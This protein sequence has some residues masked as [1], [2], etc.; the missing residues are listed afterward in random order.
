MVNSLVG[1]GAE[2]IVTLLAE[3]LSQRSGMQLTLL[4]LE[5]GDFYSVPKSVNVHRLYRHNKIGVLYKLIA[6]FLLARELSKFVKKNNIQIVQSHLY[7]A[8]YVNVLSRLFGANHKVELVN[9][10][11][12]SR[13]SLVTIR[14]I[15]NRLLTKALYKKADVLVFLSRG[16]KRDFLTHGI[17]SSDMRVINN[18]YDLNSIREWSLK[19]LH[20]PVKNDGEFWLISVGRLI[21]L[22]RTLDI[23]RAFEK[24]SAKYSYAR[25][26]LVGDGVEKNKLQEY[27]ADSRHMANAVFFTGQVSNPYAYMRNSDVLIL[28]SETEGFPNVIVEALACDTP[29]IATD[30]VSGPR[31]IL[32]PDT[33]DRQLL[34]GEIEYAQYGMLIPVGDVDCLCAA[35][36]DML[37]DNEIRRTYAERAKFRAAHFDVSRILEHYDALL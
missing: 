34:A 8:N 16:M 17:T 35:M 29:V 5:P 20:Y 9:H 10:S 6:I 7:R 30:C 19:P 3:K 25:L 14:G 11:T 31:E 13:F 33:D 37:L 15:F 24:L 32:A 26:L 23:L 21:P 18:P 4:L 22:K 28:A 12:Y 36:E 2:K 27:V 1:G